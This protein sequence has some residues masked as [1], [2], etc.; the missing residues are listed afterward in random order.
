VYTYTT[1]FLPGDGST[2]GPAIVESTTTE[3]RL[4][5][6]EN[7]EGQSYVV[8]Q[9]TYKSGAT[10]FWTLFRQDR[11]GLYE[12][13]RK[14]S[15]APECDAAPLPS[16]DNLQFRA[17]EPV[18]WRRKIER[19]REARARNAIQQ[20]SPILEARVERLAAALGLG[21]PP[22]SRQGPAGGPLDNEITRLRYPL[23]PGASWNMRLPPQWPLIAMVEGVD[24]VALPTGHAT[25]HR[26]RYTDQTPGSISQVHVWYGRSGYLGMVGH[27][28]YTLPSLGGASP[29]TVVAD[30][31]DVL[32]GISLVPPSGRQGE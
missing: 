24:V 9:G 12:L 27:S 15:I 7:V 17:V 1:R 23:R 6:S 21:G 5:C 14:S 30:W 16:D 8:Q 13:Q 32:D 31:S 26:I 11:A 25:A 18:A 22:Q 3:L 20:A 28:S 4:V 19:I 10:T 2:P 29:D